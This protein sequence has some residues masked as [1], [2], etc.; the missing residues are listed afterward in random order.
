MNALFNDPFWHP[1]HHRHGD[2]T[3][4]A[5]RRSVQVSDVALDRFTD[6]HAVPPN[7]TVGVPQ[8]PVPVTVTAV[9]PAI[10]PVVGATPV[11]VGVAD[12]YVNALAFDPDWV[13]A[14]VTVTATAPGAPAAGVV[15]VSDVALDRFTDV[16]PAPPNVT[17][18]VPE[19]PVPDTVTAVPPAIGPVVGATPVTVGAGAV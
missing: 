17:V 14:F 4:C 11:T 16:H 13:S 10:G 2:R 1:D 18:G 3:R 6:V 9:P 19:N 8:N 12:V 15:Q 5:H 7:V